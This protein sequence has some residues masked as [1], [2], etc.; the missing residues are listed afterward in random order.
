MK[1]D[2]VTGTVKLGVRS[3]LPVEGV[4]II[5]RNDLAG[6]EV[7]PCPIVAHNP[8]AS[9]QP[10]LAHQFPAAFPA[11][12][13]TLAQ[14]SIFRYMVDLS[15]SF[16]VLHDESLEDKIPVEVHPNSESAVTFP[17]K[18][19]KEQLAAAQKLDPSLIKC[20]EVAVPLSQ[21]SNAKVAYFGENSVLMRK[22]RHE[23]HDDSP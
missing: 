10:D 9:E 16:L 17:L 12:I 6:G 18:V 8:R 7:F 5:L 13:A 3:Q 14:S 15:E 23:A 22:W 4:G 2:L 21:V 1:S 19:C 20:I 11:C